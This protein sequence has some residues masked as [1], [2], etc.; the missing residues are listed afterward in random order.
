[1][2]GHAPRK[3]LGMKTLFMSPQSILRRK[4]LVA[5]VFNLCRRRLKPA[6]T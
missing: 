2:V 1:M 4:I 5:Q 6:A 3:S